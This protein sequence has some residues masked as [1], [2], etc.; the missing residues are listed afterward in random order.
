MSTVPPS[1]A[2]TP[3]KLDLKAVIAMPEFKAMQPEGQKKFLLTYFPDD[4]E[5]ATPAPAISSTTTTAA[6]TTPT[7]SLPPK[8][9]SF[10]ES[11]LLTLSPPAPGRGGYREDSGQFANEP[12]ISHTVSPKDIIEELPTLGTIAALASGPVGAVGALA[13]MGIAGLGGLGGGA[14]KNV[15][16]AAIADKPPSPTDAFTDTIWSGVKE[17]GGEGLFGGISKLANIA[18]RRWLPDT[19]QAQIAE[20]LSEELGLGL[21]PGEITPK[22]GRNE[23]IDKKVQEGVASMANAR[24]GTP[25][26][27]TQAGQ[28]VYAATRTANDIARGITDKKFA[29]LADIPVTLDRNL[30]KGI[31]PSHI[32]EEIQIAIREADDKLAEAMEDAA[33]GAIFP[34][35]PNI[36]VSFEAMKDLRSKVGRATRVPP[37]DEFAAGIDIGKMKLRYQELT[38]VMDKAAISVRKGKQW[39]D[40]NTFSKEK[41][42]LLSRG[43]GG[44]IN[45]VGLNDPQTIVSLI[46]PNDLTAVRQVNKIFAYA[47]V[48]G[49]T[50]KG[51]QQK[52]EMAAARQAFERAFLEQKVLSV[53][54][55]LWK[56]AIDK[57]V[58]KDVLA[59]VLEKDP[60]LLDNITRIAGVMENVAP[61][62]K[63]VSDLIALG[64]T[65]LGV[66]PASYGT[67]KGIVKDTA[68]AVA[69]SVHTTRKFINAMEQISS[70][71][72]SIAARGVKT[73]LSMWK[74]EKDKMPPAPATLSAPSTLPPTLLSSPTPPPLPPSQ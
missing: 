60:I 41:A 47:D 65:E 58:G 69:R 20:A 64:I 62:S 21:K 31:P 3:S 50:K 45:T 63:I 42:D 15:A 67:T 18:R 38:D 4:F 10:Y 9:K 49:K 53:S 6:T 46:A 43:V 34:V 14:V 74:E 44:Q 17:A 52:L 2:L 48:A 71:N 68:L 19:P 8:P 36:V 73:L 23:E 59:A 40:F 24:L 55:K 37:K 26:S 32:P 35:E 25:L 1:P 56:T 61:D 28:A 51:T 33:E 66:L 27:A 29:V 7:T 13:R 57:T 30:L 12:P 70:K 72:A 54:P 16:K 11:P 22:L 5:E 39:K